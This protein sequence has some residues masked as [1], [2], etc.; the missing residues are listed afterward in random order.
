MNI[1]HALFLG[2]IEGFT[3]FLPISSTAHIVLAGK[4]LALPETEFLKSFLIVIQFGSILAVVA[5]YAKR[6]L[7]DLE[8]V[9][10][11]ITAFLPTA[12][13]GFVLYKLIKGFFLEN[14][15]LILIM[16]FLGGV[17]LILFERW[18]KNQNF[19]KTDLRTISYRDALVIGLAQ[20]LAVVPGVSRA[21]A[22]IVSG[23]FL[24]ID[25][26]TMVQF[27]FLLAIPTMCAAAGYDLLKS[28]PAFSPGEFHLLA[29]GFIS[30]FLAALLGIRFL[31]RFIAHHD[32][33][34]FGV[35]RV[36]IAVLGWFLLT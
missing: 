8:T 10:K 1:L 9:K 16:L 11:V 21:A 18:A 27:S 34:G 7:T 19:T 22:T 13:I 17:G 25:R 30:S 33:T 20:S 15:A 2:I 26:G 28:A 3:E 31:L 23:M 6:L 4:L 36:I 32:F 35:Y 14:T 24:K 29:I 12:L 5:L